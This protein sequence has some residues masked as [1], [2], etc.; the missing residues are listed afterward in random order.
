MSQSVGY[1]P[2]KKLFNSEVLDLQIEVKIIDIIDIENNP[3]CAIISPSLQE[4][5]KHDTTDIQHEY[6]SIK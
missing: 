1:T 3:I 4:S 2:E 5:S 6:K